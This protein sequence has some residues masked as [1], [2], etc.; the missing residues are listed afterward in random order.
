M[1]D[2]DWLFA[3]QRFGMHPGLDRVQALLTRLGEPQR[4]FRSVLV[5]GTNGKGSTAA[6]LAAMLT[7][8]GTRVGLFTS[9]HLTRFAERFVVGGRECSD[10]RVGD[11]LRRVRPHAEAAEASFFEIVT[12][13]GCLLFAEVGVEIAVLE[14]G[15]GG[16]LDATNALEPDLSVITTVALDHTEILGGT[17]EAIAE[18]KAGILRPGRPAV[19]G[20]APA[21]WPRLEARRADLWALGREVRVEAQPRGWDGW[22]LRVGLPD[23]TLELR[24]PL[25]GK[26][27]AHNA[28]LAAAAAWRLGVDGSAIRAG[29][30]GV[31]WP[32]RLEALPWQGGRVLL[33]GAHN[34]A[35]AH[36]L[37]SALRDLGA[38]PLPLIFGAASGKDVAGVASALREA[39]S[40]VILTRARLSPRA[41]PPEELAPH[42]AGLPVRL[43]DS[44]QDALALLPEGGDAAV[45]GSLYLIGEVRPLLLG[46][47][48]EAR[49]RWQ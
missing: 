37:A 22:D 8:S 13:L 18:E 12:A 43:A 20:V 49:E 6:S 47:V 28:A 10:E 23:G 32:G 33:D 21:L 31:L 45:C 17:L 44:P 39:A 2:L 1:S 9:P 29:A 14:V 19:T 38:S 15:L 16:R 35:G 3:R 24:T 7:A 5:G 34:P 25:L 41:L 36:A 46:E 30:A 42:F 27:G 11:T 48:P 40:E 26:H 4:R